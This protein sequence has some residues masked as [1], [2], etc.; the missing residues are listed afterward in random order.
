MHT[1]SHASDLPSAIPPLV[2][3]AAQPVA[4][5]RGDRIAEKYRVEA[6]VGRGGASV[7]YR[8]RDLALDRHVAIKVLELDAAHAS[9]GVKRFEREAKILARMRSPHVVTLHD[10]DRLRS[11]AVPYLVMEYLAGLDLAAVIAR[12]GPLPVVTAVNCIMQSCEP[13]AEIHSRGVLHR[14]LKPSNLFLVDDVEGQPSPWI[15][16]LDFGIATRLHASDGS[17]LTRRGMVLGTPAYMA[18]ERM[19]ASPSVDARADVWSLGVVLYELLTGRRPFE[20]ESLSQIYVNM[21][22]I[23]PP[24]IAAV[25]DDV[26]AVLEGIVE[27]CLRVDA[28]ERFPSVT[29]LSRALCMFLQQESSA[30]SSRALR[31]P[32]SAPRALKVSQ[33][34]SFDSNPATLRSADVTLANPRRKTPKLALASWPSV[35]AMI[36]TFVLCM[37]L[38]AAAAVASRRWL[39]TRDAP[40]DAHANASATLNALDRSPVP[41]RATTE[42]INGT[43]R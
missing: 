29:V 33:S 3:K 6:V 30:S 41:K 39:R 40:A 20:G 1:Y 31:E 27:R 21:M 18:P 5:A 17:A 26:P 2:P 16:V 38:I 7:V 8:A 36:L 15:K 25:R 14:D 9:E 23:T 43:V 35:L 11:P 19:E 37:T 24:R 22:R 12:R 28:R 10:F 32:S 13:V 4:F 34:G 42:V